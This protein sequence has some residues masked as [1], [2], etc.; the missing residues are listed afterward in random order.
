[1]KK[2]HIAHHRTRDETEKSAKLAKLP[3]ENPH[4]ADR[5]VTPESVNECTRK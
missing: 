3:Q 2:Q 1:M 5:I 4:V